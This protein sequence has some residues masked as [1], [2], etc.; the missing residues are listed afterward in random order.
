MSTLTLY[1]T[2]NEL[3]ASF[4]VDRAL[5]PG[6]RAL[7]RAIEIEREPDA[8]WP[9]LAQLRIAPYSYDWL[10]NGFRRSP[11]RL[12]DAPPLAVGDPLMVW[13][14]V[15]DVEPGTSMT[16]VCRSSAELH[17]RARGFPRLVQRPTFAA[18]NLDWVGLTYRLL[19]T[20]SAGRTR[21]M[22]KLRWKSRSNVLAPLSDLVFER[23]DRVMM[24]R[25]LRNLK[26]LAE[27]RS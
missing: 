20:P 6:G 1:P 3:A 26:R 7:F 10:D 25:Q 27:G 18:F 14:R 24:A 21:L 4:A 2:S 8:I 11:Q 23:A 19:P 5:E 22:V 16:A 12:V 17:P 15:V 9:W 13:L